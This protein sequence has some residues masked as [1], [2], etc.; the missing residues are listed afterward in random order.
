MCL[1]MLGVRPA[2]ADDMT[3]TFYTGWVA[4]ADLGASIPLFS[5]D[6]T[7]GPA[8]SS[9][10]YDFDCHRIPS[11]YCGNGPL[12]ESTG[13]LVDVSVYH[14]IDESWVHGHLLL[15]G[16]VIGNLA[17]LSLANPLPGNSADQGSF[18]SLM[19]L[20]LSVQYH[21]LNSR[22][23][24]YVTAGVGLGLNEVSL[25]PT[26]NNYFG[27]ALP[28]TLIVKGGIGVDY[29]LSS[30]FALNVEIGAFEN[31]GSG[32]DISRTVLAGS[33]ANGV[34]FSASSFYLMGGVRF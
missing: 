33:V 27:I 18:A 30:S 8:G 21:P 26:L 15:G 1:L 34:P 7:T 3:S 5:F 13:W 4:G 22:I 17:G 2:Y 20:P 19:I 6:N 23:N 28:T 10:I 24:P 9:A 31:S 14:S 16:E 11:P 32:T 29:I 12:N 25:T